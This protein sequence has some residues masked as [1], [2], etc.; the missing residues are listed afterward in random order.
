MACQIK[1]SVRAVKEEVDI[2]QVLSSNP[3]RCKC[4]S[5]P[6][7]LASRH[8]RRQT[9]GQTDGQVDRQPATQTV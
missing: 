5:W 4:S 8:E 3:A 1:V 9:D 2:S 6:A 7:E